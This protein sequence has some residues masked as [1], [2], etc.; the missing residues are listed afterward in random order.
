MSELSPVVI[1]AIKVAIQMEIE[2]QK[3]YEEATSKT[4]NEL[5]KKMFEKLAQD[6]AVHQKT[7]QKMFDTITGSS[8]WKGLAE[9]SPNIGKVPVF[10]GEVEK[11]G[12]VNQSDLDALRIGMESERKSIEHYRK[13]AEATLDHLAVKILNT[14][15][16]EEEYH[17]D[18]LQAQLDYLSK[19]GY[20][21]DVAEYRMDGMY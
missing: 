20:W 8:E 16:E 5:G 1:D 4:D 11:K 2:G 15:K 3:F 21:F 14:I 18:L 13:A 9:R 19:S 7:F 6:E 12:N 10:D 17:Y